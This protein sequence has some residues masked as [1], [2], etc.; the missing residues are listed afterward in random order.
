MLKLPEF[1][2]RPAGIVGRTSNRCGTRQARCIELTG[3]STTSVE[4]AVAR[5]IQRAHKTIKNLNWFQVVEM[6][7]GINKGKVNHRQVTLKVGSA[8]EV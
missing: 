1:R 6:R 8:V 5:A 7:G 3:T 2:P 4:D